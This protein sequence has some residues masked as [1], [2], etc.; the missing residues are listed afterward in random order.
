M[1]INVMKEIKSLRKMP[2]TMNIFSVIFII[3]LIDVKS[4]T[5]RIKL[6]QNEVEKVTVKKDEELRIIF[7]V[8]SEALGCSFT[9]PKGKPYNMLRGAAYEEGRI[10]QL[11]LN[12]TDCA[13]KITNSI[14]KFDDGNW[15]SNITYRELSGNYEIGI[16]KV[17]VIV[18]IPP[19]DVYLQKDNSRISVSEKIKIDGDDF[20]KL[21]IDCFATGAYPAVEFNWYLN[22]S[23]LENN[24]FTVIT[25]KD[26]K[27][28]DGRMTYISNLEYRNFNS[29]HHNQYLKCVVI[30]NNENLTAKAQIEFPISPIDCALGPWDD[31]NATCGTGM[32]S[33]VILQKPLY[34]GKECS[35][36]L[37]S[38]C[39]TEPCPIDCELGSWNVC[40]A[41]CGTGMQS[42]GIVQKP[43]YGGKECSS[44]LTKK[45][46]SEPCP[47]ERPTPD[48]ID[49]KWSKWGHC[50]TSC[51][52]GMDIFS[53]RD[54][55]CGKKSNFMM[56]TYFFVTFW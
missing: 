14:K 28:E 46:N 38:E 36:K 51:G 18:A 13:M 27:G 1:I 22:E 2:L 29:V 17:R 10:Q 39:N 3:F 30:H 40:N 49:C 56:S 20:K 5:I 52:Q 44:N 53:T 8:D 54:K 9:S 32:K 21:S 34:G 31:C 48:A 15:R 41:K 37:T 25:T 6:P 12:E 23:K 19:D 11:E 26:N 42:R 24:D 35:T 45:C 47:T 55:S 7:T 4:E 16:G 33:R 50:S 43:L